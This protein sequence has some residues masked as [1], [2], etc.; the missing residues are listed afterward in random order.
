MGLLSKLF[1]GDRI[2]PTSV[3]TVA[4]F[5]EFVLDR[6]VPV[7]IDIWSPTC[8]PCKKLVPVLEDV[9][10]SYAD[11]VE[12]VEIDTH[13]TEPAL[14]RTLG[15]Q[16]T[17]TLIMYEAGGEVGRMTGFRPRGWFD[18]MISSEFPDA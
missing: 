6:Q 4:Q 7:I 9:A 11:R 16:A 5:K 1:G 8:A 2:A 3:R 13:H 14:L 15:V 17:P 18:Q 10:T 12:V